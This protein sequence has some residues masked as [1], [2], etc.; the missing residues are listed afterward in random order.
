MF[1]YYVQEVTVTRPSI[2]D[3]FGRVTATKQ[4]E[5]IWQKN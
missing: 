1:N 5:K 2:I 3:L 4:M